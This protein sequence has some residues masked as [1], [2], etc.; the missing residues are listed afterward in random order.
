MGLHH[1]AAK[2]QPQPPSNSNISGIFLLEKH[3][4]HMRK[5]LRSD[6]WSFVRNL[7]GGLGG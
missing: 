4:E 7:N 6:A 1:E 2:V 3:L 5:I